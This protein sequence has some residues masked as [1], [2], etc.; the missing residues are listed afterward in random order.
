[1]TMD[2]NRQFGRVIILKGV[3]LFTTFEGSAGDDASTDIGPVDVGAA[4][5]AE[6]IA[7][8]Q[9]FERVIFSTGSLGEV[10]QTLN[11]CTAKMFTSWG[12]DPEVQYRLQ[13]SAA[14]LTPTGS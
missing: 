3:R 4:M 8:S 13:R 11:G 14:L 7:V 6:Q 2:D 5:A 1:M 12:L 10:A 9:G